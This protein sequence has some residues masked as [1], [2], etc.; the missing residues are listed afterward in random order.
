MSY[1]I[2]KAFGAALLA[3]VAATAAFA[4]GPNYMH[5]E[6]N[7]VPNRWHLDRYPNQA[8]PVYTDLGGL[9]L[10]NNA[11]TT[12]W[13]RKAWEQWSNVPTSRFKAQIIGD[14]SL[15]GLGDITPANVSQV[16]PKFNGGGVTVVYDYDGTIFRDYLGLGRSSVLGI[17]FTEYKAE[18]SDEIL[19]VTVFINGFM[20]WVNDT[21][22]SGMSGVMT[23]E[24]GHA[25]NLAHSQANGAVF[26]TQTRDYP[27]PYGCPT[28]PYAGGLASGPTK[29]QIETM[30]PFLD[31]RITGTSK[32]QFTVDKL[33][34]IAAI[35]DLYPEPGWPENYGTVTGTIK[36]LTKILGNGT[37]PEK[38]VTGVNV[39]ARNVAD[40]YNDFTSVVSGG[41]T[42]GFAGEDGTFELHGLT[43]GA[44]YVLYVDNLSAGAFPYP[45]MLALPGPEEWYNA[46]LESGNGETDDRCAWTPITVAAQTTQT[47]DITFNRVKGAPSITYMNFIGGLQSMSADGSILAGNSANMSSYWMWSEANGYQQIG[48]FAPVGGR[49]TLSADGSKFAGNYRD[50]DGIV[51]WGIRDNA[52]GT[53]QVVPTPNA[54]TCTDSTQGFGNV[55]RVGTVFGLSGD[56]STVV[57]STYNNGANSC[58]KSLATKWTAAGGAQ[59]LEKYPNPTTNPEN[60]ANAVN[61]DGSVIVGYDNSPNRNGVYWKNGVEHFMGSPTQ[62]PF[63][64]EASDVTGDGVT[65]VGQ[66]GNNPT[67]N[68]ASPKGAYKFY[69][70]ND[71]VETVGIAEVNGSATGLKTSDAGTVIS[72]FSRLGSTTTPKIWTS[73]IGWSDF[74]QFL[75]SQGIYAPEMTFFWANGISSTGTVL[76][77]SSATSQ[78]TVTWRIEIPKA[79]VCHKSPGGNSQTTH[80]LDVTFPVGLDDHLAHGDTLGLC[81]HGGE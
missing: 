38:Q 78:G 15:L 81:E 22:G 56:G 3:G 74:T 1:R 14:V 10:M 19:E 50:T 64:G 52:T 29:E 7:K 61:Y 37:G 39:I 30:Y 58:K 27:R 59:T 35:S 33:D 46:D 80:N 75:N 44:Q 41:L 51:K 8:V 68:P 20:Q 79:I 76:A 55:T 42:R 47:A 12:E 57:G 49:G 60:R 16:Y 63:V 66:A 54:G 34:D 69:T 31:N 45:R 73:G 32:F 70:T 67:G 28:G 25:A 9:G 4:G 11:Q 43:P 5:D 72:G 40:P 23:H 48:G 18:G 62:S 24:F 36:S 21:D 65:V 6:A 71:S 53:W 26:N 77:G 2:V 13:V 17:A